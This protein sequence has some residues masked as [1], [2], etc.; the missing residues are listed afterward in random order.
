MKTKP[1]NALGQFEQLVITAII[2]LGDNAYGLAIQGKVT[3]F[4]RD[5]EV[6]LGSV[7]VTLERLEDKGFVA[8]KFSKPIP[9]RGGRARR[10]FRLLP[11][12]QQALQESLS[13]QARSQKSIAGFWRKLKWSPAK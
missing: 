7:Y 6:N 10:L 4:Y 1:N 5:K 12:G 2:A 9:E 3:E 8:S 13:I 11:A